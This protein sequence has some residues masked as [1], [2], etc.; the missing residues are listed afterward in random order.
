MRSKVSFEAFRDAYKG[1]ASGLDERAVRF[2]GL[3]V[4]A[5]D[6]QQHILPRTKDIVD[7]GFNGRAISTYR[8]SST[9]RGYLTHAYDVLNGWSKALTFNPTLNEQ[10]DARELLKGFEQKSLTIY[11]RLYFSLKQIRAHFSHGSYFLMRCRSNCHKSVIALLKSNKKTLTTL[12]D[13]KRV[14]FVKIRNI[15][16]KT[17][18][19]FCTNLPRRMVLRSLILKLYR[20]R[21]EVETSFLELTGITKSEQWHSKSYNGI[22]QELYALIWLINATK[23]VMHICG[24]LPQNPLKRTYKKPNFKLIFNVLADSITDLWYRFRELI[25]RIT[26]LTKESTEKRKRQSRKYPRQIRGPAS[27]YPY[28]NTEWGWDKADIVN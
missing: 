13:G 27:P 24:R 25:K 16:H 8:E 9:P 22:M 14:T 15:R 10:A 2:M 6:G 7:H 21:W 12:I 5:I 28:N 1:L 17:N 20:L 23:S 18:D 26:Q 4:Y 19:V 11:D 3:R